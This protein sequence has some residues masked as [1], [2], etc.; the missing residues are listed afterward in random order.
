[1]NT[2]CWSFLRDK[3]GIERIIILIIVRNNFEVDFNYDK[4]QKEIVCNI[5]NCLKNFFSKNRK[6]ERDYRKGPVI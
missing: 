2:H 1:M 3:H 6:I 4:L 5:E